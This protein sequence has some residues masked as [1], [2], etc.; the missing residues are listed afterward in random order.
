M[1]TQPLITKKTWEKLQKLTLQ[2]PIV[3]L[4]RC[5]QSN[6]D[7]TMVYDVDSAAVFLRH[8]LNN[9]TNFYCVAHVSA[10]TIHPNNRRYTQWHYL[11]LHLRSPMDL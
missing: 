11:H 4:V 6:N 8:R 2:C 9:K 1:Q 3:I 5:V 10:M 7:K